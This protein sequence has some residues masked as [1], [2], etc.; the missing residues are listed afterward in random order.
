MDRRLR[1]RVDPSDVVQEAQL[2]A[3]RRLPD[4]LERRPM[5]FRLWLRKT[6]QE[7]LIKLRRLHLGAARRDARREAPSPD[8]SALFLARQLLANGPT[9]S[10]DAAGRERARRIREAVERLA[11]GDREILVLRNLEELSNE[12][13]AEVLGVKPAAASQR[14]GRALLRLRK[15][16]AVDGL[17]EFQP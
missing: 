8:A 15:A 3:F 5:S 10:Q 2:E 11:E 6:A 12:E 1:A 9:P 14:Y 16:L 4:F 13:S 17:S 7:R